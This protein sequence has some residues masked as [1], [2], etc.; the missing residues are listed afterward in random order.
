MYFE[1]AVKLI[2]V[3]Q[4]SLWYSVLWK[5]MK[6]GLAY[7]WLRQVVNESM[8]STSACFTPAIYLFKLER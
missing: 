4:K 8:F 5:E 2:T 3:V 1:D 7:Y 6:D